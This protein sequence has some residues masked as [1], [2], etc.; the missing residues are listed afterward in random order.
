MTEPVIR[1]ANLKVAYRHADS[2]VRVL[3]GVDFAIARGEVLGL[4]GESGCGKSTVGLQLLGYRHPNSRVEGG[5]VLFKGQDLLSLRRRDLDRLRGNRIGFVPQ[6]PTTALNPGSG[7][8]AC[9]QSA[10]A[11]RPATAAT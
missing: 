9:A 3:H 6:N 8:L 7:T 5:Q 2:W 4:V 10:A 11:N 1:V